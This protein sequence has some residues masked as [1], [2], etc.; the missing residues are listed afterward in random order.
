MSAS[1][2]L[3]CPEF[4]SIISEE[5]LK[6]PTTQGGAKLVAKKRNLTVG[7]WSL[8]VS[9]SKGLVELRL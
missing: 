6:S 5:V 7:E 2:Q 8:S 3:V 4:G 1:F 9:W